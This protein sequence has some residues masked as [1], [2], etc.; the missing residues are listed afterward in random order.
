MS[1]TA[2]AAKWL[3]FHTSAP[4]VADSSIASFALVGDPTEPAGARSLCVRQ[5]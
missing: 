5:Q 3:K 2:D 4:V 1:A